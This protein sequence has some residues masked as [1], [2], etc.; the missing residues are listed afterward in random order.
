MI[1]EILARDSVRAVAGTAQRLNA[2]REI[3]S[4][5]RQYISLKESRQTDRVPPQTAAKLEE[6]RETVSQ[7]QD[8]LEAKE[9]RIGALSE[10]TDE[11]NARLRNT[12][13]ELAQTQNRLETAQRRIENLQGLEEEL[14]SRA[15]YFDKLSAGLADSAATL[16]EAQDNQEI[17]AAL[18]NKLKILEVL[19]SPAVRRQYPNMESLFTNYLDTF[20]QEYQHRG[21]NKALQDSRKLVETA[22]RTADPADKTFFPRDR[23]VVLRSAAQLVEALELLVT[24]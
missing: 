1:E 19:K 20:E 3:L 11:L 9:S 7:Q 16:S 15:E 5:L 21:Y 18:D 17:L 13:S 6:L 4:A 12:R 8:E 10:S 14:R 23:E 2:D 24:P 22:Q